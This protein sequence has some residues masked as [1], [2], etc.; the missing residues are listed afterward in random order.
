MQRRRAGL[1][2]C[3]EVLLACVE[4]GAARL[5]V[6]LE[7]GAVQRRLLQATPE[8]SVALALVPAAAASCESEGRGGV[9]DTAAP[10]ESRADAAPREGRPK[11]KS[12]K[13]KKGAEPAT[14]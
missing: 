2:D 1:V 9:G 11:T 3:G 6:A 13:R 8:R 7:G 12:K 5:E 4:K 10:D 14:T